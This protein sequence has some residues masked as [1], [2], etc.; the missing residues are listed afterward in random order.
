MSNAWDCFEEAD[1]GFGIVLA[2]VETIKPGDEIR[3]PGFL[4]LRR[5]VELEEYDDDTF[6]VVYA[7]SVMHGW[8]NRARDKSR[9]SQTVG[10][11]EKGLKTMRRGERFPVR[12]STA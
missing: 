11:Y 3:L 7:D 10:E 5:V 1:P 8:E 2:R 9:W 6:V 4:G 12:R